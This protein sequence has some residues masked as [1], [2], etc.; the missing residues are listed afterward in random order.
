MNLHRVDVLA[1]NDE[2]VGVESN[3]A[4]WCKLNRAST[5]LEA[6][7][8]AQNCASARAINILTIMPTKI[9]SLKLSSLHV[10][11]YSHLVSTKD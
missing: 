6:F 7:H 4:P 10:R 2:A 5:N 1:W 3:L 9:V 11:Q 8:C